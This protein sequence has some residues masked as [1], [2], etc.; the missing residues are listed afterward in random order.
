MHDDRVRSG[1]G[2]RFDVAFGLDNHQVRFQ[3]QAGNRTQR[4]HH[5]QAETDVGHEAPIHDIQMETV[6][7]GGL[8]RLGLFAEPQEIRGQY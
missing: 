7:S 2:K 6:R 4:S 8:D 1:L 5:G 3:G